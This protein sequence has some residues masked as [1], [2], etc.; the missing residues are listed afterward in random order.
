MESIQICEFWCR[1]GSHNIAR[2]LP[3]RE[4]IPSGNWSTTSIQSKLLKLPS[5]QIWTNHTH[6][7][8]YVRTY[9]ANADVG[10]LA[11]LYTLQTNIS[12]TEPTSNSSTAHL[13][14]FHPI[15]YSAGLPRGS[16]FSRA[17]AYA[18]VMGHLTLIKKSQPKRIV[19]GHSATPRTIAIH[20]RSRSVPKARSVEIRCSFFLR[21]SKWFQLQDW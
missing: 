2:K 11:V 20:S 12:F 1:R 7:Y 21:V 19:R 13:E 16:T 9:R 8:M 17:R 14:Q 18:A 15:T 5:A 10:W 6:T 4:G 3:R